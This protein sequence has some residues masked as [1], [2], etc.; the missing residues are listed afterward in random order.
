MR[1]ARQINGKTSIS[2]LFRKIEKSLVWNSRS[3]KQFCV[4]KSCKSKMKNLWKMFEVQFVKKRERER[5]RERERR[6]DERTKRPGTSRDDLLNCSILFRRGDSFGAIG[7]V[8]RVGR[9]NV[10]LVRGYMEKRGDHREGS[11]KTPVK[12]SG[13]TN[14]RENAF[15]GA[16]TFPARGRKRHLSSH[17]HPPLPA[18]RRSLMSNI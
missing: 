3:W 15:A 6:K 17:P 2:K 10:A 11:V 8:A 18:S 9:Q 12:A 14:W 7:A 16:G 13:E 1:L 4:E 5:E